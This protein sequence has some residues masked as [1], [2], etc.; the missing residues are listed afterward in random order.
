[1]EQLSQ[2]LGQ[3]QDVRSELEKKLTDYDNK[4]RTA[5][6]QL[7]STQQV[8]Q[9]QENSRTLLQKTVAERW[10]TIRYLAELLS[11]LRD[12]IDGDQLSDSE[13]MIDV[14]S[15]ILEVQFLKQERC[16]LK[17]VVDETQNALKAERMQREAERLQ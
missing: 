9:Q 4:L 17:Q 14:A 3:C 7:A 6:A 16:A 2:S 10:Q 1:N 8:L 11:S 13:K 5:N 12:H 15:T